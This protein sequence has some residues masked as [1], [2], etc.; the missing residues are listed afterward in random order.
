MLGRMDSSA[1]AAVPWIVLGAALVSL[2]LLALAVVRE[3]RPADRSRAAEPPAAFPDDDLPGFLE[4]PPGTPGAQAAT[5][6]PAAAHPTGPGADDGAG[7]RRLLTALVAAALLLVAT[8]AAV[9]GASGDDPPPAARSTPPPPPAAP[10][11]MPSTAPG[12]PP[13]LPGVPADPLP[14]EAGAGALATRSV[15]LGEDGVAARLTFGGIVLERHAVGISVGYPSVGVTAADGTGG[16]TA[17]AHL[18]LPTWNCLAGEPP[19]DPAAA[20]CLPTGVEHADLPSPA[21]IVTRED[22]GLR[23][24]GRFPTYTRPAG[25]PASYT[26]RVF[27]LTVTAAP[28]GRVRD[29]RAAAEGTLFLGTERTSTRGGRALNTLRYAG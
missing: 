28:D 19:S 23:L 6:P 13:E 14:G 27:E 8:A 10:A 11:P 25:R 15:P 7:T 9:A 20:G 16:T 22:D 24:T 3:R 4:A 29:G 5:G 17:L 2:A 21:L 18:R 26:G 12:P 1:P